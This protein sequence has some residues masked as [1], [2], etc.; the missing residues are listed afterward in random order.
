MLTAAQNRSSH[1][2]S[3]TLRPGG[4]P[5]GLGGGFPSK[6]QKERDKDPC[7]SVSGEGSVLCRTRP[8]PPTLIASG[9]LV[10]FVVAA[11]DFLVNLILHME[12]VSKPC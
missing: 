4:G 3:V 11:L 10:A 12:Q 5:P 9:L 6:F 1:P 8:P 2:K 7:V